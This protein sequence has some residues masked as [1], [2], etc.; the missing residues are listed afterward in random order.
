MAK[1]G[2]VILIL[3]KNNST[4]SRVALRAWD[5]WA[6]NGGEVGRGCEI[7]ARKRGSEEGRGW[8]GNDCGGG[9]EDVGAVSEG[10]GLMM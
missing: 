10:E 4:G 3:R 2:M 6:E 8:W 5:I 7:Y 9:Y 1:K